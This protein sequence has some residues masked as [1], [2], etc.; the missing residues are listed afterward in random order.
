ME[1]CD[2]PVAHPCEGLPRAARDAF[3]AVA[4]GSEPRASTKTL[5]LLLERELLERTVRLHYFDDGLPPCKGYSYSIPIP[6]HIAWCEFWATPARRAS[7]PR[8]TSK[9]RQ[10]DGSEPSLFYVVSSVHRFR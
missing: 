9:R 3:D 10:D 1:Q 2:E 5:D 8:R 6:H 4:A 7:P